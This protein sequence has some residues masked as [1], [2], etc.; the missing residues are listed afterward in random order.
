M[1]RAA[2]ASV[3]LSQG[4]AHVEFAMTGDGPKL[5]ELGARCGGSCTPQIV[6]HVT[7]FGEFVQAC[8]M[9]CGEP[10]HNVVPQERRGGD[11]RF[12][13]LPPGRICC[14]RI[15]EEIRSDGRIL[16]AAITVTPGQEVRELR[17]ASERAGFVVAAGNDREDAVRIADFALEHITAEYEGGAVKHPYPLS[18]FG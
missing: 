9:A 1:C 3:G 15:P 7:G 13:V 11:F 12:I 10:P 5:F 6:R 14:A 16:D 18:Y 2:V 17:T 8:L 4:I